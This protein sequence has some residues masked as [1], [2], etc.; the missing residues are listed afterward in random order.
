MES[1]PHEHAPMG[2]PVSALRDWPCPATSQEALL[3]QE[4]PQKS[5]WLSLEGEG[6]PHAL[7]H[8]LRVIS[9]HW[10]PILGCNLLTPST[11]D[12]R[13]GA[14]TLALMEAVH[15]FISCPWSG[16]KPEMV[17]RPHPGDPHHPWVARPRLC[18]GQ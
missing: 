14:H 7:P 18:T 3:C 10:S 4:E 6:L 16:S 17:T 8:H 1:P 2:P 15:R 13:D 12:D 5:P 11:P 9:A